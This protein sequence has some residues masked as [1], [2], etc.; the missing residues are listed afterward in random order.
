MNWKV[1]FGLSVFGLAM[2]LGTVFGI[3]PRA[4]PVFWLAI[5]VISAFV[6]ARQARTR[7]FWHGFLLGIVN[8]VWV[9]GAHIVFYRRYLA[10]HT[11]EAELVARLQAPPRLAIPPM[12]IV[13][14]ASGLISGA[15]IGLLAY[16]VGKL[17]ATKKVGPS[18]ADRKGRPA[19]VK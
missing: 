19:R 12:A 16:L 1:I 15:V 9:T 6:I 10:G 8:A 7:L 14:L 5:F 2:G 18:V 13:G 17:L 3:S 4:E 11:A